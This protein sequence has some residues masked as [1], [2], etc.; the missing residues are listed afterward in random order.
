M[1]GLRITSRNKRDS[2]RLQQYA[3]AFATGVIPSSPTLS[4]TDKHADIS[5]TEGN[6]RG[7]KVGSSQWCAGRG[8]SSRTVGS[9]HFYFEA[10]ILG[11][12][13]VILGL[14]KAAASISG[15]S[16]VG[17]DVN[18]YSVYCN[19]GQKI[20]NN[21]FSAFTSSLAVNDVAGFL[22]NANG[23]FIVYKNGTLLGT[24][25]TG[26]TGTF[27]PMISLFTLNTSSARFDT[28]QYALPTDAVDW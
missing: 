22:L 16:Y 12:N 13:Q 28:R 5:V 26:L 18:G 3:S 4:T 2:Y 19:T 20:N 6:K 17:I 11:D 21:V 25:F 27:F 23:D 10:T 14:G 24:A 15:G 9:G 8:D 1:A 7:T